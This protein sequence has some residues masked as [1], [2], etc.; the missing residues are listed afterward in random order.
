MSWMLALFANLLWYAAPLPQTKVEITNSKAGF[1]AGKLWLAVF[2]MAACYKK[3]KVFNSCEL[4]L[5]KVPVVATISQLPLNY[6]VAVFQ[7]C[8]GKDDKNLMG[9]L[10]E[11]LS[12]GNFNA[13]GFRLVIES[14]QLDYG[15]GCY[16]VLLKAF[17]QN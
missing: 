7:G 9:I 10:V 8:N 2:N 11:K 15:G 12:F 6:G 13:N 17:Q 14:H 1:K 3:E 16:H 5:G 4:S